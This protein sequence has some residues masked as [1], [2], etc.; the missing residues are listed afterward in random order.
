MVY[1]YS[2]RISHNVE[3]LGSVASFTNT[4]IVFTNM[5]QDGMPS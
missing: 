1:E 5:D 3:E 4:A 2:I